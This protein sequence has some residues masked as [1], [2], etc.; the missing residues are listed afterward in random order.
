MVHRE[1]LETKLKSSIAKFTE[2]IKN[3]SEIKTV[4]LSQ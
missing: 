1:F 3:V 4:R 2:L